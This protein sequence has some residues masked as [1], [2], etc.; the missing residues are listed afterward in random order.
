M[1]GDIAGIVEEAES[2]G[3]EFRVEH[4]GRLL[5]RQFS[6][7]PGEIQE[8]VRLRKMEV[9]AYLMRA[10][11]ISKGTPQEYHKMLVLRETE[12]VLAKSRLTGKPNIDWYINN[13]IRDLEIKISD[14][15]RWLEEAKGGD[16]HGDH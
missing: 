7:L 1:A 5:V 9:V 4:D 3:A 8:A 16:R 14:T 11:M 15:K 10:V 6:S 13:R 12:L 2:M